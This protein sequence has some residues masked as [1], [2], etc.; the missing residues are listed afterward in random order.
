[1][2]NKQ[3]ILYVITQGKWGGAQ[4]YVYDLA[5]NLSADFEITVAIGQKNGEQDL[6]TKLS[7][8]N[9]EKESKI[10]L[11]HLKHLRRSI[12]P[13]NDFL[14]IYELKKIYKKDKLDMIHLN[15]SK[16]GIIGSLAKLNIKNSKLIY[17]VHGWVFNEPL[18]IVKIKL[19][20]WLEKTTAKIKDKII[21]L[22]SQE[23]QDAIN[24][25]KVQ[26]KKLKIIKLGTEL[27]REKLSKKQSLKKLEIIINKSL[28]NNLLIGTI[29][30][31]YKTK[32]LDILLQA[33]SP[34]KNE[35]TKT[36]FILIGD[37]PEKYRL[38][39]LIKKYQLEN[40]VYLAGKLNNASKYLPAFDL[41]VLPSRKEGMPFTL[42]EAINY[43]IPIIS[44]CVGGIP[45]LI[46]NKKTGL[47]VNPVQV[48]ELT[49]ALLTAL[50]HPK[51][52]S[53]YANNALMQ[54][55]RYSLK[56]MIDDTSRLYLDNN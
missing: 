7:K 23:R 50:N 36:K 22:S 56:N 51:N 2:Q 54:N 27:P 14:A 35:L 55:K 15:S 41:F 46:K 44:T 4:K 34:I 11:I 8:W 18:G 17:T 28:G 37:G 39:N 6:Q 26:Q 40:I 5:T 47:L 25:L 33:I 19:Y 52:M 29:A 30:N 20:T 49:Q 12:S 31:F 42:L 9:Q 45:E 24:K 1:M 13:I 3:K 53:D 16:A 21:V 43:K 32:G 38:I 10:K 48:N